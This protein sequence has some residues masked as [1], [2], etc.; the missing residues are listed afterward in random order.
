MGGEANADNT[1]RTGRIADPSTPPLQVSGAKYRRCGSVGGMG[2]VSRHQIEQH[3][4]RTFVVMFIF[5]YYEANKIWMRQKKKKKAALH[6]SDIETH[7]QET[8]KAGNWQKCVAQTVLHTRRW[9]RCNR[10]SAWW[11]SAFFFS[12]FF[13]TVNCLF[14]P[15]NTQD[16][17]TWSYQ[18]SS[19]WP[20][21]FFGFG[22]VP[23][24]SLDCLFFTFGRQRTETEVRDTRGK[25]NSFR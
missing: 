5:M 14:F 11:V 19:A 6:E 16:K 7:L 12:L 9:N 1:C 3:V 22:G 10:P 24:S 21:L 2:G 25:G 8:E 13:L 15:L 17:P 20:L 23:V 4:S 18:L